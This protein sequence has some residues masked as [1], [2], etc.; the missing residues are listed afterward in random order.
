MIK[1]VY[2]T[3]LISFSLLKLSHN[4]EFEVNLT[5]N[6]A[7]TRTKNQYCIVSLGRKTLV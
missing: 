3:R 5:V 6:I 7:R 1:A 2:I 4:T